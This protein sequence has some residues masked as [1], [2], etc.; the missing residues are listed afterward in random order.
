MDGI[1][2]GGG[3]F[4]WLSFLWP[5]ISTALVYALKA[6]SSPIT[7]KAAYWLCSIIGGYILAYVVGLVVRAIAISVSF[8]NEAVFI[9]LMVV[10]LL[11]SA[12]VPFGVALYVV[13]KCS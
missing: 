13:K 11:L 2:W 8:S 10:S 5:I 9:A 6:S 7:N 1:G 4:I 3:V 12:V